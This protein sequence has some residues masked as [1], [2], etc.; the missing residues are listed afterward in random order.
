MSFATKTICIKVWHSIK[1]WLTRVEKVWGCFNKVR[2]QAC[3]WHF[4]SSPPSHTTLTYPWTSVRRERTGSVITW[5]DEPPAK[6]HWWRNTGLPSWS[7][8]RK[9]FG[10]PS[11]V[12]SEPCAAECSCQHVIHGSTAA[13]RCA[14]CENDSSFKG[15]P[16]CISSD[17]VY[18]KTI[19]IPAS[20]AKESVPVAQ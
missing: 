3:Y 19:T 13:K 9:R 12:G 4:L 1:R 20:W 2:K 5:N 18:W 6:S 14:S 17:W 15:Q 16:E 7:R 8:W 11:K 10:S